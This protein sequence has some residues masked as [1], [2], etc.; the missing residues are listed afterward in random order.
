METQLFSGKPPGTAGSTS[1]AVPPLI[2]RIALA[3]AGVMA[4]RWQKTALKIVSVA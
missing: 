2:S 3:V 4:T 1:A